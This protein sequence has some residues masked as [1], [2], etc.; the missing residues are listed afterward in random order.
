[1]TKSWL[2]LCVLAAGAWMTACKTNAPAGL[3]GVKEAGKVRIAMTG[4]FPPF[5]YFND[6]NELV[7]FDVDVSREIAHRL[8][9]DPELIT[10]RW[11]GILA[12][13]NARRY[14]LIIGS[15]A[16]TA[17]RE[18]A[19]DFSTPYY[20]SGAQVF[21]KADS[22]VARSGSLDGAV[23]GVNLGTTYEAE[24]RKHTEVR[25][26]RTYGGVSEL[27]LDLKAGRIDAFVTD[28][29]VGLHAGTLQKDAA[30]VPAGKLLYEERIGIAM[31]KGQ[32]ELLAAV[33]QALTSMK[34]DGTTRSLRQKW[35]GES[36][37]PAPTH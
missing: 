24:L 5:N 3:A 23:V 20:T 36:T 25:E 4:E 13:L 21:T 16:I 14:E 19:V 7:G 12:G 9:V 17:E 27:I 33:N 29:L 8:A 34:S 28:K 6:K 2:V 11:D 1:M 10:L 30:F 37:A 15:M 32:P 26:V 35:F 22:A 18:K 31:N